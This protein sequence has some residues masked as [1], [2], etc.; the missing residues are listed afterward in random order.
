M[1]YMWYLY[2]CV[3]FFKLKCSEKPCLDVEILYSNILRRTCIYIYI[4]IYYFECDLLMF[5]IY[6]YIY[7]WKTLR[8]HTRN[9]VKT[10]VLCVHCFH[11]NFSFFQTST[12]V[13][14]TVWK[15]GKCFFWI[16]KKG[17]FLDISYY[18]RENIPMTTY[19]LLDQALE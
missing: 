4:Y 2:V 15:H 3:T 10:L 8:D 12:R 19:L 16:K 17:N 13:F 18:M 14:I 11:F 7:I 1:W 9:N 5:S 6:I